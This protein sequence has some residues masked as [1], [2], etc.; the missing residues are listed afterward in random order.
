MSRLPPLAVIVP[1]PDSATDPPIVPNIARLLPETIVILPAVMFSAALMVRLPAELISSV[2]LPLV[3][4]IAFAVVAV[5]E[6]SRVVP[7]NVESDRQCLTGVH[8]AGQI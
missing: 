1:V 7:A 5:P 6:I 8:R 4:A 3:I 2:W